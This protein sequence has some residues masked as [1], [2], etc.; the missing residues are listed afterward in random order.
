MY[1]DR[2]PRSGASHGG[3]NPR[4]EIAV[5]DVQID[6]IRHEMTPDEAR[7]PRPPSPVF[8]KAPDLGLGVSSHRRQPSRQPAKRVYCGPRTVIAAQ[9]REMSDLLAVQP[10]ESVGRPQQG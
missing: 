6:G 10:G 8:G 4:V 5:A 3:K 2:N 7:Q 9:G 1:K